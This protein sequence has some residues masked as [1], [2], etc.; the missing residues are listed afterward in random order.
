MSKDVGKECRSTVRDE[1]SVCFNVTAVYVWHL[2][3]RV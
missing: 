1:A 3:A 2:V